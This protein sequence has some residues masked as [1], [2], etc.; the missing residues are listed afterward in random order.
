MAFD[1]RERESFPNPA[2]ARGN[3]RFFKLRLVT[4]DFRQGAGET[5]AL[6]KDHLLLQSYGLIP[7][8]RARRRKVFPRWAIFTVDLRPQK[9]VDGETKR[10]DIR[11]K[12]RTLGSLSTQKGVARGRDPRGTEISVVS[13][14]SLAARGGASASGKKRRGLAS[15]FPW[16]PLGEERT[17]RGGGR[18]PP[19]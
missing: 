15:E 7:G 2:E 12:T 19:L 16:G 3:L 14:Q 11:K 18:L 1:T 6:E 8:S 9:K 13:S 5:N 10:R 17:T 4:R